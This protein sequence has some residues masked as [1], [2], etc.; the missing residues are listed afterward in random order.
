MKVILFNTFH[1]GDI[2]FT[3][4]FIRTI[5]KSNP[6]HKFHIVCRQ[7]YSLFSDI[8]NLEVLE[9]PNDVDYNIKSEDIDMTKQYYIFNEAL[10]INVS[11]LLNIGTAEVKTGKVFCLINLDCLNKYFKDNIDGANTLDIQPKLVF[12]NLKPEEFLPTIFAGMEL[13]HL[14]LEVQTVLKGP[15]IYYYNMTALSSSIITSDEDD[16]NIESIALKY[17]SYTVIVPKETKIKMKNVISLYDLNI[18]ETPDGKNL[19]VYAYVA[20]FCSVIITKETGGA[21][22]ILNK[23]MMNSNI[24]QYIIVYYSQEKEKELRNIFAQSFVEN[25]QKLIKKDNKH[26]IPLAKYDAESLLIEIDKI[27]EIHAAKLSLNPSGGSRAAFRSRYISKRYKTLKQKHKI[28]SIY[29]SNGRTKTSKYSRNMR[30][31]KRRASKPPN[32]SH[33]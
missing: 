27:G 18:K 3:K 1:N 28:K 9:R 5:V 10:Y 2:Y 6:E 22:I 15:C 21:L 24:E 8:E 25:M 26:L 16:K 12:N 29:S 31:R 20:S 32:K 7:F 30:F 13:S 19:L 33:T 11:T 4:E 14:P 23:D 17:P